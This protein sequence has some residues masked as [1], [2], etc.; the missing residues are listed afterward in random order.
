MCIW[1]S[2]LNLS[3]RA[4]VVN[5]NS[6]LF[7]LSFYCIY[8]CIVNSYILSAGVCVCVRKECQRED[9][10]VSICP[11]LCLCEWRSARAILTCYILSTWS[12]SSSSSMAPG[13]AFLPASSTAMTCLSSLSPTSTSVDML[14]PLFFF[15][16]GAASQERGLH[17]FSLQSK[18]KIESFSFIC[19]QDVETLCIFFFFRKSCHNCQPHLFFSLSG[20]S[21]GS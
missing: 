11:L 12:S 1:L 20:A 13:V 6:Y 18:L 14:K 10:H 15:Y 7:S 2:S 16:L 19:F 9:A 3:I 8:L 17:L 4:T 21:S 5:V